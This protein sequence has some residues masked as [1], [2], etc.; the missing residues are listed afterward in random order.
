MIVQLRVP[1]PRVVV[2]ELGGHQPTL[3]VDL[4]DPVVPA[5]GEGGLLL[6]EA[7]RLRDGL[8]M[9]RFHGFAGLIPTQGPEQGDRL[10]GGEHQVIPGDG[11]LLGGR[12]SGD[13]PAQLLL[14]PHVAAMRLAEQLATDAAPDRL[15]FLAGRGR[16]GGAFVPGDFLVQAAGQL[17]VGRG[18][19]AI[20]PPQ[21]HIFR[22]AA[23]SQDTVRVRAD[24]L[25]E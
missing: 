14:V 22:G 3:D 9:R 11:L 16:P 5:A 17:R 15:P 4:A 12:L 23:G 10:C 8:V 7:Q 20:G 19:T 2:A 25:P 24:A 13:E 1:I 18:I 21:S 6:Q